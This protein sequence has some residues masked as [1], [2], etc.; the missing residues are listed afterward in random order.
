MSGG[1]PED[2]IVSRTYFV[3]GKQIDGDSVTLK[4][5]VY[6]VLLKVRSQFGYEAETK[7]SVLVKPNQLPVCQIV[8]KDSDLAWSYEANC[9][10]PDGRIK[11]YQWFV[12]GKLST[13][14]GMRISLSKYVYKD[15]PTLRLIVTDNSGD[16][17]IPYDFQ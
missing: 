16:S 11:S 3:D 9:R 8:H 17:S 14:S 4:K 2:R 15:K 6:D 12:N 5:G 10:D 7:I 1:H 13:V